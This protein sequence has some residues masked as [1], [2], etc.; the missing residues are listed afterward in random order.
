M[1]HN[2]VILFSSQGIIPAHST[3]EV[4]LVITPQGLEELETFALMQIFGSPEPPLV[5]LLAVH[6]TWSLQDWYTIFTPRSREISRPGSYRISWETEKWCGGYPK[7]HNFMGRIGD[8][9][10][11]SVTSMIRKRLYSCAVKSIR[12]LAVCA[13]SL[14]QF[15]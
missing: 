3:C 11:S 15:T 10:Y 8:R 5:S 7:H 4:P 6:I 2:L 12:V 14:N 13:T 1:L 9:Y